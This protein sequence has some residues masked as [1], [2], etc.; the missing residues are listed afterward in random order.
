[1]HQ[2]RIGDFLREKG[3]ITE[4]E[5]GLILN[6][7]H[8]TGLRF[9]EAGLEIKILTQDKLVQAFAPGFKGDFFNVSTVHLPRD[10]SKLMSVEDVIKHGALPL[11]F[12]REAKILGPSRR[13]ILNL[14]LL[15]PSRHKEVVNA[16]YA[17]GEWKRR[18]KP[19]HSTNVYL[20][21]IDQ[22]LEVLEKVYGVTEADVRR[23]DA[24]EVDPILSRFLRVGTEEETSLR[25][26]A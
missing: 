4:E 15:G 6:Y 22:F 1:M 7:S 25:L 20:V 23:F 14:G 13:K 5:I 17:R 2:E 26:A 8:K 18:K 12:R 10:A 9:C 21:L 11:G 19:F 16:I 3:V 24:S